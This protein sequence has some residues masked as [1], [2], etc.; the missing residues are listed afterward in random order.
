MPHSSG[1]GRKHPVRRHC[2]V[3]A[4]GLVVVLV[5]FGSAA[6]VSPAV[7]GAALTPSARGSLAPSVRVGAAPRPPN[8]ARALGSLPAAAK[9]HIDVVLQPRDPAA[10]ARFATNVSTPGSPLYRHYLARGQFPNVFGPTTAAVAAVEGALRAD[11]LQ[12][13]AISAN[14]LSIPVTATA[15][16]LSTA[17]STEFHRYEMPSGRIAFANTTAPLF[18]RSVA[19]L[20]QAVIG[21]DNLGLAR[22]MGLVTA[23]KRATPAVTPHVVTGGPQPCAPAIAAGITYSSYTADQLASAY[24]FSSLYGAGDFGAGQTV[25]IYELAPNYTSDISSYQTCYGTSASVS[26]VP[27]DG[28]S[29]AFGTGNGIEA[30]LDIEDVIGLAPQANID[31]YQGPNNGGSGPYDTYSAIVT[32]DSAQVISTSWGLCEPSATASLVTA[33]N[34]LFEQAATQGQSIFAAAGDSG[35]E[36][37]G[38]GSATLAVDDPASQPYVTGVG[39]TTLTALGPPPTETVW[40]E[41]ASGKGAGGGGIS[42]YWTMPSYQ[43]NAP[44]SLNVINANSSG[45]ACGAATGYCRQVPDV[46]AD[47]DPYSGYVIY[48]TGTGDGGRTGWVGAGGTSAATPLW[49]ALM[50]L[51]N[52]DSTCAGKPIGFANPALYGVA[53]SASYSN[54]FQDVT[55]GNNDYTGSNGGLYPAGTGYDMAS[56]LGTPNASGLSTLLCNAV[57]GPPPTVTTGSASSVSTTTATLNGTVNPNGAATTYQFEYGTTTSYGSFSP[58]SPASVGSGTSAVAE[59]AGIA[60]LTAGVT[61]DFRIVGT[62]ANGTTSGANLTFTTSA[63]TPPSLPPPPSSSP[64]P[65]PPPS[66]PSAPAPSATTTAATSVTGTTAILA[67]TVNPNGYATTYQF[68]YGTTTAY[69]S[70]APAIPASAGSGTSAVAESADLAGLTAGTTYDFRI[71][72]TSANGTTDGANLTLTTSTVGGTYVP[73]TPIRVTDTRTGSGLPNAGKPL[74]AAGTL[75]VTVAGTAASD[76]V[77][78][79]ASAIVANVT[80]VSPSAAGF[81]TVY[82]SGEAQPTVSSL[83]F[84]AGE[85]TANLV[86]VPIGANGDITIF[87]HAGTANALVDVYG[88]YTATPATTGAGLY[89]AVSP[90]RAA[91]TL[92]AG[93]TI[94]ANTSHPVTV[95]GGSTGV[96]AN[97]SAVVVNL[98]EA[99][100]TAPSFLT[101]YGAGALLPTVSN[102]NFS[103]GEVR[104]NRAT[105]PVGTSGQIEVYNHTGSVAVDVDIDGYYTA[106]GGTGS[107]FVPITPVRVTDTRVPTNGGPIAADTTETF[108]LASSSVPAAASA[109]AANFT[110][111]SGAAPG[112]VTVYPTSDTAAPTASD[113]NWMANGVVPN[114]TIADTAGAG[115]VDVFAS[116][117]GAINLVIDEFG[118]FVVSPQVVPLDTRGVSVALSA[119]RSTSTL[120]THLMVHA[121]G[122]TA[123]PGSTERYRS[124]APTALN[125]LGWA[126]TA[127]ARLRDAVSA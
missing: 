117:G 18:P 112:Y 26:Y 19:H 2:R 42:T 70:V 44:S 93:A 48:Y 49:A 73:V 98:T 111:V 82:P 35:S 87:N 59:S 81:F 57:A 3:I 45:S 31:V 22:P 28:G 67:G 123:K 43:A 53:G 121:L 105:V 94:A 119:A 54:A 33:E 66:P 62:S 63:T 122:P 78:S 106:A 107:V 100:A 10:L 110:V 124:I 85:T 113:I 69:G 96:P 79:D 60:G 99:D 97:A 115:K 38:K 41:S 23:P 8:A 101:A 39:G 9:L 32:A 102:L 118:Y 84:V 34:T 114:F 36:D 127:R 76:G 27:V 92:Q 116:H 58:A 24:Q 104:A 11:G 83:N 47:A 56:G 21:L 20:V 72:G 68:E 77:P 46:S 126:D 61:Y 91:G 64:P 51:I 13:G 25:A 37:C 65:P 103:T 7:A 80:A 29:G 12:L 90:Y 74:G 109:V 89:N 6:I 5:G 50:A 55:V 4:A 15:A 52:A 108:S 86:T 17:F 40:N 95:T 71:V 75:D 88:Y 16:R 30:A 14:H 120:P 1:T 125:G